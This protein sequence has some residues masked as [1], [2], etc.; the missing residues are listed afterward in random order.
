MKKDLNKFIKTLKSVEK[1]EVLGYHWLGKE[2]WELMIK[3][4]L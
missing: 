4:N 3:F 2:K 1:V